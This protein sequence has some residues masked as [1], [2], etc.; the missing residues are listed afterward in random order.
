MLLLAGQMLVS[1]LVI[2]SYS[3]HYTKLYEVSKDLITRTTEID[4]KKALSTGDFWILGTEES[5]PSLK[6]IIEGSLLVSSEQGDFLLVND[7]VSKEHCRFSVKDEVVTLEDLGSL[8]GTYV[9]GQKLEPHKKVI[10]E[11]GD[12][13]LVGTQLLVLWREERRLVEES[14]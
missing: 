5:T 14:T 11:A 1:H 4:D 9:Q 8:N 12:R 3:I 7:S 13:I 2:T 6:K 10:L